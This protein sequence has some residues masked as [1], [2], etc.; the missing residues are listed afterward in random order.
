[1]FNL[2]FYQI[3]VLLISLLMIY[4]GLEKFFRREAGQ[5]WLKVLVRI[6][7][8]GG[9]AAIALFPGVSNY[10]AEFVGLQGNVNAVILTGFVLVFLLIFKIISVVERLEQRIATLVRDDALKAMKHDQKKP[11]S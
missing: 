3:A 8:W 2:K 9:M 10:L 4:F 1:M 11:L 5:S 6:V 7:V